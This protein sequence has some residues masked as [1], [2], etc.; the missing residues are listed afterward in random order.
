MSALSAAQLSADLANDAD[1]RAAVIAEDAALRRLQAGQGYVAGLRP[2]AM[3]RPLRELCQ[4]LGYRF[5]GE[6]W[7][8]LN[9]PR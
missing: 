6:C 3:T 9:N 1:R 2:E 8:I 7:E 4:V 5:P